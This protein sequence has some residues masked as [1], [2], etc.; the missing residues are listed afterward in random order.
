MTIKMA[1]DS[2]HYQFR[3]RLLNAGQKI[4]V[5][6]EGLDN[7]KFFF[8]D[9]ICR[10][11]YMAIHSCY[12]LFAEL[13][14]LKVISTANTDS[15]RGPME[16]CSLD[17]NKLVLS[18]IRTSSENTFHAN[19]DDQCSSAQEYKAC[20][21]GI[22]RGL[23]QADGSLPQLVY[24]C[25]EIP[26]D[27]MYTLETGCDLFRALDEQDL[28]SPSRLS[29]L[30][31][32][33]CI[34]RRFDLAK[35]IEDYIRSKHKESVG[36]KP[37]RK[38]K[39]GKHSTTNGHI[40][41]QED[42]HD[43]LSLR[44]VWFELFKLLFTS[45]F[46]N[47]KQSSERIVIFDHVAYRL[48]H[49]LSNYVVE[50]F[51]IF[52]VVLIGIAT[53][54]KFYLE[55]HT[56]GVHTAT[57][58]LLARMLTH[59]ALPWYFLRRLFSF[60][61][62]SLKQLRFLHTAREAKY[63]NIIKKLISQLSTSSEMDELK[64]KSVIEQV[65]FILEKKLTIVM[66]TSLLLSTVF[67]IQILFLKASNF[68][69]F[70]ASPDY[71]SN[72]CTVVVTVA[73]FIV[74]CTTGVISCL[75]L[76]EMRVKEYCSHLIRAAG[77]QNTQLIS[78]LKAVKKAIS[79]RW[80]NFRYVMLAASSAYLFMLIVSAFTA[81]PFHCHGE[82]VEI[83]KSEWN[84]IRATWTF[85]VTFLFVCHVMVYNYFNFVTWRRISAGLQLF[86][87]GI[88]IFDPYG[89]KWAIMIQVTNVIY[90]VASLLS[91]H[92]LACLNIWNKERHHTKTLS[93]IKVLSR[94]L[95]NSSRFLMH[96]VFIVAHAIA[97]VVAVY[98]EYQSLAFN[99]IS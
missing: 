2:D 32:R 82:K 42:A 71:L 56:C 69:T 61:N 75:Y 88:S 10:E 92:L 14:S 94:A 46:H 18:T 21:V 87:L 70:R 47:H 19:L 95:R 77:K 74:H 59:V 76:F 96:S 35:K 65:N 80:G 54:Y 85:N 25:P 1:A 53:V 8:E 44:S 43:T 62:G 26:L 84:Q 73:S 33:L 79:S 12:E 40:N 63:A 55:E 90:P 34:L 9:L 99:K 86:Y 93:V 36:P 31:S 5:I 91:F 24:L 20:L 38:R 28:I 4:D 11:R 37:N 7:M 29:Y 22:S 72:V 39:D 60:D 58:N 13:E 89:P 6:S 98:R 41:S 97:V 64:D 30:Y 83:S 66:T 81:T 23:A 78:D 50:Y 15:L 48:V 16:A 52:L 45:V 67:F 27:S 68:R 17:Y 49:S 51:L 57:L 3:A